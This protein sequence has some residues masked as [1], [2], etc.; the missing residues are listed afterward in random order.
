MCP[1]VDSG[2]VGTCAEECV[3]DMDCDGEAKCCSN[4]CG[5]VCLPPMPSKYRDLEYKLWNILSNKWIFAYSFRH[6]FYH[7]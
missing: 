6:Q 2:V 3:N 5:H 1:R 7:R 4:G